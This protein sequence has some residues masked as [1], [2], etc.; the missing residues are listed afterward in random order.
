MATPRSHL[1]ETRTRETCADLLASDDRVDLRPVVPEPEVLAAFA[2]EIN[3]ILR[4][5][6]VKDEYRPAHIGAMMLALWNARGRIR[7]DADFVLHDINTACA[8]AF[9][10]AGKPELVGSL[11]IDEHN[12]RL[13][14]DAW[15]IIAILEKLDVTAAHFD[16]DYLGQLYETFFRYTGG[17]T[18]GQYFTP[19]HVTR[20]MADLC[21]VTADDVVIDPACG[22]GGFLVACIQRALDLG[23]APYEEVVSQVRERL[24]GYES[25]P[26]TAALCVANMI[27]RGDGRSGIRKADVL[28]TDG[29][30]AGEC[31]VALMNPPFPHKRTDVPPERFVERA[32]EALAPRGRLAVILPTSLLVKRTTMAWRDRILRDHSLTAVLQLPDELFQPWAS[33]TTS[34]VLLEK[35][36]PHVPARRTVFVRLQHDGLVLKKGVRVLRADGLDQTAAAVHAVLGRQTLPG[37]AGT[38]ELRPGDEWSPGAF[39]PSADPTDAEL[40]ASVDELLCRF[41]SFYT[42]YPGRISALRQRVHAGELSALPYEQMVTAARL[43]N[44]D[45]LAASPDTIG[46]AFRILYGQKELH[47]RDGIPPGDTLVVSPTEQYNGCYG[48]LHFD[49]LLEPPFVTTAQTGS[50][51]E[52]FVQCEPCGVNDDCLVLIQRAGLPLAALFLCAAT[53]RLERWRFSYGRKLTPAR[54]CGFPFRRRPDLERAVT[55]R[56]EQWRTITEQAVAMAAGPGFPNDGRPW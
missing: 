19:R 44:A 32:L 16:H 22:T 24:V 53:I 37:F 17:N 15:Q 14:R 28:Q 5:A 33:A 25:E 2:D 52:S 29:Y 13:A 45:A 39:I 56:I 3:R 49:A 41:A 38:C 6:A 50:I 12:A 40:M 9:R 31:H 10:G 11:H 20:M 4:E 7:K 1:S 43:R 27:L 18:I 36:V 54:I 48:W 47:S 55:R 30:P 46:A 42:R 34:V 21:Q 23:G 51:G 8:A 26:V 35:G